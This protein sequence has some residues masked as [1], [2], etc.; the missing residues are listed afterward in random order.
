MGSNAIKVTQTLNDQDVIKSLVR[1]Q[2][3]I[4]K[5]QAK[6]LKLAESAK[7]VSGEYGKVDQE[8]KKLEASGKKTF[9]ATRTDAERYKIEMQ[10]LNKQLKAGAINQKTFNRAA[11]QARAR[12]DS[13]TGAANRGTTAVGQFIGRFAGIGSVIGGV[14]AVAQA[15]RREFERTLKLEE[16][17]K[18]KQSE[19]GLSFAK[20]RV[21]FA[22]DESIPTENALEARV[23]KI[24][25]NRGIPADI[26]RSQL[27]A[28]LSSKGTLSNAQAAD[29]VDQA[30]RLIPGDPEV[31]GEAAPGALFLQQTGKLK[32]VRAGLGF[33]RQVQLKSLVRNPQQFFPAFSPLAAAEVSAGGD[34]E[35]AGE[36]FSFLSN[37]GADSLGKVSSTAG[38]ALISKLKNFV[39]TTG[40]KGRRGQRLSVGQDLIKRFLSAKDTNARLGL[41]QQ[42]PDLAEQFLA[43]N[44]FERQFESPI[45]GLVTG[46]ARETALLN[47]ARQG[48]ESP[49]APGQTE[50]FEGFVS[51]EFPG[52]R[53]NESQRR[54]KASGD[55]SLTRRTF[56]AR[57]ALARSNLEAL[58]GRI[59]QPGLDSFKGFVQRIDLEDD[60]AFGNGS[61][62]QALLLQLRKIKQN[63]QLSQEDARLVD[64]AIAQATSENE[65]FSRSR[66]FGRDA[67]TSPARTA[68]L[69][70]IRSLTK[71]TPKEGV[72]DDDSTKKAQLSILIAIRDELR[73][74]RG[75]NQDGA[76]AKRPPPAKALGRNN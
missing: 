41:L 16:E 17:A 28:A 68:V 55:A 19:K 12:L 62:E 72:A 1:Q 30:N 22:P 44:T 32:D 2:S 13:A 37:A 65:K 49:S 9:A 45:E 39:P 36:L 6:M 63:G 42:N 8:A 33:A 10:S 23:Q 43:S 70:D 5:T 54:T 76:V 73:E 25:R 58:Q 15:L 14:L 27:S 11:L 61:P 66:N 53:I 50:A 64:E 21:N 3:E 74:A 7:K 57:R 52:R 31:G 71:G 35:S 40:R 38:I 51:A 69:N 47:D 20:L 4:A 60:L 56:E 59:D 26:V 48:I 46:R 34:L 75:E 18:N 24:S 67:P 29:A